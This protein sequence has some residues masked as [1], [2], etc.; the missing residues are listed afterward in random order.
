[1]S[2]TYTKMSSGLAFTPDKDL[3]MFSTMAAQGKQLSGIS[4]LGHGWKFVEAAPE[5]AVFDMTHEVNPHPGYFDIFEAAG[6]TLVL[7]VSD[8][9]IFKAAPGTPPVHTDD[10][11]R[12]DELTRQRNH[13]A[14]YSAIALTTLILVG[15]ALGQISWGLWEVPVLVIAIIPTVYT[16]MPLIGYVYRLHALP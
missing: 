13:F 2:T 10:S 1:M 3:A 8:L 12:R 11:S 14:L 4:A 9:H 7:S 6:W 16:V 15:L 5:E